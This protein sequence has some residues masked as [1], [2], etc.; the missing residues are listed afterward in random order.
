MR[1]SRYRGRPCSNHP[2]LDG[3]RYRCNSKCVECARIA[4]R[5]QIARAKLKQ[6]AYLARAARALE[7]VAELG[8]EDRL[9]SR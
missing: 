3:L 2:E 1:K 5:E 9:D 6:Q 8:L 4:R 7:L